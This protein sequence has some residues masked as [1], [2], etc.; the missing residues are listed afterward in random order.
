VNSGGK[1]GFGGCKHTHLGVG[2]EFEDENATAAQHAAAGKSQYQVVD[3][4]NVMG[5]CASSSNS[6]STSEDVFVPEHRF[7]NMA[8]FPQRLI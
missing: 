2:I 7:M 1:W 4:W 6:V 8:E 3:D 5:L